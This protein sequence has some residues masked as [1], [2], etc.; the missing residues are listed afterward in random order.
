MSLVVKDAKCDSTS[1]FTFAVIGYPDLWMIASISALTLL[2]TQR[3]IRKICPIWTVTFVPPSVEL[4]A[5][6]YGPG[7]DSSPPVS[8]GAHNMSS[9]LT[10]S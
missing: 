5:V 6:A 10:L 1:T 7:G 3:S 4:L 2:T 8:V 9:F